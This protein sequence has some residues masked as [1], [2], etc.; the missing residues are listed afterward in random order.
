MTRIKTSKE[1][2]NRHVNV[3]DQQHLY[4]PLIYALVMHSVLIIFIGWFWQKDTK[5]RVATLTTPVK[6]TAIKS[7]LITA[8]QYQLIQ[9]NNEHSTP[10]EVLIPPKAVIPL[11]PA[12]A[13]A[14]IE[15]ITAIATLPVATKQ[16][17]KEP[18]LKTEVKQNV[19]TH[20]T[21][22][23]TSLQQ[24]TSRY[25]QQH[26][27][28][29]F[30]QLIDLQAASKNKPVGTMSE[31]DATLD[32]IELTPKIDTSQPQT[33]NHKLD[34][35]RIVKQGDYCYK[36][37][38]LATQVNPHGWGLGF[39]EFCGEDKQKQQLTEAI[40]NRVNKLKKPH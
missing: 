27:N 32:F 25:I 7:Y 6:Y 13:P 40:N 20:T 34:P 22:V 36:V 21:N 29:Q 9:R 35:N 28:Q 4:K 14:K 39:A 23:T 18:A 38:N 10:K 2:T 24:A 5:Q 16:N 8:Q 37:V 31:M 3:L 30:E 11:P 15:P 17:P 26:N 12:T 33:L 1:G 19:S